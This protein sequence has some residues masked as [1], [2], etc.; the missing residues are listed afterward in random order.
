VARLLS[1]DGGRDI[2]MIDIGAGIFGLV[3]VLLAVFVY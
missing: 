1:K 3:V 2:V